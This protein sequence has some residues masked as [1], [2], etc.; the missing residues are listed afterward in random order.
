M[1]RLRF[2]GRPFD[3]AQGKRGDLRMTAAC[4]GGALAARYTIAS[5][6]GFNP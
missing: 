3:Q 4:Q 6:V 5:R 1:A 2:F